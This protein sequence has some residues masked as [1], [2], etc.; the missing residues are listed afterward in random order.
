MIDSKFYVLREGFPKE[1]APE[2]HEG[3]G[4]FLAGHTTSHGGRKE[5]V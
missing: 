3:P 1:A 4:A 5:L 2:N